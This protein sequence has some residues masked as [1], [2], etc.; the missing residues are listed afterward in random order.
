MLKVDSWFQLQQSVIRQAFARFHAACNRPTVPSCYCWWVMWSA[1]CKLTWCTFYGPCSSHIDIYSLK[2][3]A[4]VVCVCVWPSKWSQ[5][6]IHTH[7]RTPTHQDTHESYWK[8]RQNTV[9]LTLTHTH[10]HTETHFR[11]FRPLT[12]HPVSRTACGYTLRLRCPQPYPLWSYSAAY[13]TCTLLY[14]AAAHIC[15]VKCHL[16]QVDCLAELPVVPT[17]I[18]LMQ[19]RCCQLTLTLTS[20]P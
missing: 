6:W 14:K 4:Q 8:R 19:P 10:T 2:A 3:N 13:T 9:T 18:C 20:S 15:S 11:I 7:T 16:H 17:V 5:T 1:V 12:I